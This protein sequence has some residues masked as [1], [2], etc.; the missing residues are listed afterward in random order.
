MISETS[1]ERD[2]GRKFVLYAE[3]GVQEYWIV[4]PRDRHIRVHH[5][6]GGRYTSLGVFAPGEKIVTKVLAGLELDP[7]QIFPADF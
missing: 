6:E 3:H 7:A 4:D 1:R 5:L 2:R